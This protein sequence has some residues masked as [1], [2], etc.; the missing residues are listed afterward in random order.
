MNLLEEHCSSIQ[1]S[2]VDDIPKAFPIS[3]KKTII[4]KSLE[5]YYQE[6]LN[7]GDDIKLQEIQ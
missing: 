7:E 5:E 2:M 4:Q 6:A 3:N 1:D